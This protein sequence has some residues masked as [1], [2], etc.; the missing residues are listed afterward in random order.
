LKDEDIQ[1]S[2]KTQLTKQYDYLLNNVPKEKR[3]EYEE[4]KKN[5]FENIDLLTKVAKQEMIF[6]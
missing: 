6:E 1:K 4:K 3:E 2:L 5:A